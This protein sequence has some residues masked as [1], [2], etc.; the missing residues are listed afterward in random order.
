[1]MNR[2]TYTFNKHLGTTIFSII[3]FF[4]NNM[5]HVIEV[6]FEPHNVKQIKLTHLNLLSIRGMLLTN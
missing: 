1:M 4:K 6:T 5:L 3:T 2:L